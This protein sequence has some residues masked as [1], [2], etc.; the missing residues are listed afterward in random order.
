ME[1]LSTILLIDDEP[2][3]LSSLERLLEED[4]TVLKAGSG[5]EALKI[6]RSTPHIKVV[7][8]DQRMPGML[9]HQV[10]SEI[11]EI[12]PNTVRMLLTGYSDLEAVIGS[13]NAGAIFRYINKPWRSE[14]LLN[15]VKLGVQIYDRIMELQDQEM[16]KK[17]A[18]SAA[19]A[20]RSTHIE[21]EEKSGSVLFVDY[22]EKE[23]KN[24]VGKFSKTFDVSAATSIDDAFKELASKPISV[25][26]SDV[27]F[28][29]ADGISF[30]NTVRQEYPQIVT[31]ILTEVKDA[32]LAVRS[33]N[34]LQVF[35]YLTKPQSDEQLA[36][37]LT[38]A[39]AKNKVYRE[40]PTRNIQHTAEAI[41]P[42]E[43]P[44]RIEE[45]ELRIR[46]RAAQALL[47]RMR[48]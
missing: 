2:M 17:A 10:L 41:A 26:V 44:P 33:I 40:N 5:F 20:L 39:A 29:D 4:Y 25:I 3:I 36:K 28:N 34:E 12:S 8:S 13:V 35:K 7:I 31:V 15:L 48:S 46:L 42:P 45:S 16:L 9:G 18:A 32:T 47:L 22:D 6:V 14:N 21:V 43:A 37:T 19:A 27:N 30:L 23:L 1:Q 38:D 24:L 11:K